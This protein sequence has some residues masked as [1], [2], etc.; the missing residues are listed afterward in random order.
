MEAFEV[1][2][3]WC[4]TEREKRCKRHLAGNATISK[5]V[6]IVCFSLGSFNSITN[7]QASVALIRTT[8]D[9]PYDCLITLC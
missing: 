2:I 9:V 1:R 3:V 7:S 8:C 4:I 6:V 5:S